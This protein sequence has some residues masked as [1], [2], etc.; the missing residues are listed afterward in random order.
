MDA[1]GNANGNSRRK[2]LTRGAA[3]LA[4]GAVL[5]ALPVLA[6]NLPGQGALTPVGSQKDL[7][8][9]VSRSRVDSFNGVRAMDD[10]R[11]AV[12]LMLKLP[13]EDPR[14]WYRQA[15]I[16]VLDCPHGNAWFF[17]WHRGY[18][19]WFEAIVQKLLNKPT[20]ALPFWEWTATPEMPAVLYRGDLLDTDNPDFI[21]DFPTFDRTFRKPME[22]FW[23]GLTEPQSLQLKL[24]GFANFEA[25]WAVVHSYFGRGTRRKIGASNRALP[26]VAS[27]AVSLPTMINALSPPTLFE[28]G[29]SLVTHHSDM[30]GVPGLLESQAHDLV[31]EAVDGYMGDMLSA[32]DPVFWL[33]HCNID[34]LWTTWLQRQGKYT[35]D[36]PSAWRNEP[37]LFFCDEG[38]NRVSGVAGDYVSNLDLDY[39]FDG[40]AEIPVAPTR[41]ANAS[42]PATMPCQLQSTNLA[43]NGSVTASVEPGLAACAAFQRSCQTAIEIELDR[44]KDPGAWHFKV[45]IKIDGDPSSSFVH[46]GYA[47]FFG[48]MGAHPP[49]HAKHRGQLKIG[50]ADGMGKCLAG[51][52]PGAQRFSIVVRAQRAGSSSPTEILQMHRIA[53]LSL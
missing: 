48:S 36:G 20:F 31:H 10:L 27:N 17:P 42:W 51:A 15:L 19:Y 16:H 45:E 30:S 37:F 24:R 1:N 26:P 33:H 3:V 44:P 14:N 39:V 22:A 6:R 21:H 52:L 12:A 23:E 18:L 5:P 9:M 41:P 47:S 46:C 49:G 28:F 7:N 4:A 40:L 43:I 53:L 50:I 29:G 25:F 11:Q 2:F 8:A 32:S 35:Q 13:P 38:G 34:R